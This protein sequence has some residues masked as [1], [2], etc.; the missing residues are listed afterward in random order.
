MLSPALIALIALI[1]LLFTSPLATLQTQKCLWESALDAPQGLVEAQSVVIDGKL[2][3]MGGFF[4]SSLRG[5]ARTDVYDPAFDTWTALDDMLTIVTHHTAAMDGQAIW[6]AGGFFGDNGGFV[7]DTVQVYDVASDSWGT[8]PRLP[9]RRAGGGLVR[10]GRNLHYVGGFQSRRLNASDHFVLDLDDVAAGWDSSSFAPLPMGRGHMSLVVLNGFIYA[11]GGQFGHD[12]NPQDVDLVHRYDLVSNTW[13]Q[14]ASLPTP[15]SHFEAS[16]FVYKGRIF[17]AGGRNNQPGGLL[18]IPQITAYDPSSDSWS[19]V[20]TLPN[21]LIGPSAKPIGDLLYVT[22]GGVTANSP[23][24]DHLRRAVEPMLGDAARINAGGPSLNLAAD[25]C[26]DSFFCDG[27]SALS[28]L[29]LPIA[30]T[31]DD[32]LYLS[33]RTSNDAMGSRFKYRLPVEDGDYRLELHF[34]EYSAANP[35]ERVFDVLLEGNLILDDY[36]IV[37]SVGTLST[38]VRSF[39]VEILDGCIELEFIGSSGQPK[40]SGIEVLRLPDDSFGVYCQGALNSVGPGGRLTFV[41]STSLAAGGI[42]LLATGLPPSKPARF[43][44]GPAQ[45]SQPFGAGTLCLAGAFVFS[46]LFSI[47]LNGELE[48]ELPAS[49][50]SAGL[51][52]NVQLIYLDDAPFS[53]NASDALQLRFTN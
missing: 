45:G 20:S 13:T 6:C 34:A 38:D 51:V 14:V 11:V 42:R 5:T 53:F 41:G 10:L 23:V 25:W 32:E 1:A 29:N 36:D 46:P 44:L 16:T 39:D 8:G 24:V 31:L 33:E 17:I 12:L 49:L 7:V 26:M 2:Y 3:Q 52:A 35:G 22:G 19:D 15:R 21:G 4:G 48:V 27:I 43:V 18:V 30:S 50:T 9:E 28:S 37:Q 47:G 40:L